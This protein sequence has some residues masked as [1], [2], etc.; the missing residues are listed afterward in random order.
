MLTQVLCRIA[1]SHPAIFT[2]LGPYQSSRFLID[3]TDMPVR[4]L[5]APQDRRITAHRHGRTAPAH[6]AQIRGPIR[7][8]LA[9]LHGREDGDALF[10]SGMLE[11]AGDTSAVLALRNALDDAELDLTQ[12]L[13][14]WTKAPFDRWA[15]ALSARIETASGYPLSRGE[16]VS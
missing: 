6:D 5:M 7:A 1:D 16:I 14:T 2:R 11:I 4:L 12:E 15:R 10:F 9:M 8:F 13:S 3:L